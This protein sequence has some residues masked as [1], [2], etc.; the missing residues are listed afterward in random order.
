MTRKDSP[1]LAKGHTGAGCSH[2]SGKSKRFEACFEVMRKLEEMRNGPQGF[3]ESRFVRGMIG[4]STPEG[5]DCSH[6]AQQACPSGLHIKCIGQKRQLWHF[7]IWAVAS[8]QL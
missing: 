2:E 8:T 5:G 7:G 4:H 1:L 6:F 3:P